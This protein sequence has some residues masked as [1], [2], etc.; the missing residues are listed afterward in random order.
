MA[1]KSRYKTAQ[2]DNTA[3]YILLALVIAVI[4][5]FSAWMFFQYQARTAAGVA[6]TNFGPIV[7]R[8]SD[9]SLRATVSVQSRSANA[10]VIDDRQQQIDFALQTALANLDSARARRADG[11]AYVQEA[12][13]D[14]VNLVLGTQ[15]VEDVLLTDFIIQQN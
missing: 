2:S 15:A 1:T 3:A 12:M 5:A 8:G 10:S 6:Y 7:V 9:Y 13:R 4:C 14:S 11:V